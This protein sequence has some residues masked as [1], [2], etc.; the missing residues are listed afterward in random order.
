MKKILFGLFILSS[1]SFAHPITDI[2]SPPIPLEVNATVYSTT[3]ALQILGEDNKPKNI[4]SFSHHIPT[5]L[6]SNSVKHEILK[7]ALSDGTQTTPLVNND[8][9]LIAYESFIKD[10][11]LNHPTENTAIVTKMT[12]DKNRTEGTLTLTNTIVAG[13]YTVGTYIPH[14]ENITFIY[15][16]TS[17]PLAQ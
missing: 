5:N 16:K 13:K 2:S 9:D 17:T 11:S 3:P 14:K 10:I 4:L 1:L 7:F 8:F 15:Y 6:E 12:E